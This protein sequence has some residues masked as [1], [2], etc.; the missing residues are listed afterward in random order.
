V[1]RGTR[2]V[3][4]G[5][6]DPE[7]PAKFWICSAPAH[8]SYPTEKVDISKAEPT[9][10]GSAEECNKRT[11][12]KYFHPQGV[13]TCQL[14]MGL[15]MLDPGS[16]WNTMPCH[17]HERRMEVYLYFD[18]SPDTLVFHYMG[19]PDETRHIVMRNEQAVISPSWS[20]HSGCATKAYTFI[21]GMAGEN[22]T[23]TD[24]DGVGPANL[25]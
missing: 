9:K 23:F 17:T 8:A 18:M 20:I 14:V 21:W 24:M 16:V 3:S 11:I 19:R 10:P 12:Y 6:L 15:T 4:F 5:S 13:K 7:K 25:K 2:E 1:G 22:Q